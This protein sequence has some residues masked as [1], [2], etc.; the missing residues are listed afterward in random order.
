MFTIIV[1]DACLTRTQ[2]EKARKFWQSFIDEHDVLT[3]DLRN[4][5]VMTPGFA[6][7]A[8]GKLLLEMGLELFKRQVILTRAT[9]EVKTLV[10]AVLSNRRKSEVMVDKRTLRKVLH[11]IWDVQNSYKPIWTD[12]APS[13]KAKINQA[14]VD[15]AHEVCKDLARFVESLLEQA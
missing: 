2:G 12:Q 5:T 15:G 9:N 1:K 14:F 13:E 3:I 7:E 8:I 6:D 10:N 11:R 4:V